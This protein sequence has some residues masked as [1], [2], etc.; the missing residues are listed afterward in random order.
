MTML[1]DAQTDLRQTVAALQRELE[2]RTAERD[3]ALAQEAATAEVL[4]V[5]NSSHARPAAA[6]GGLPR[7]RG[8][9]REGRGPDAITAD[10]ES[11]E[12]SMSFSILVVDDEPDI[13]EMFRQRFRREAREGTYVLHFATSGEGGAR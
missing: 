5:I 12:D 3:E 2:T 13:A 1:D 10:H 4:Q 7:L 6:V 8:E 11:R 9:G